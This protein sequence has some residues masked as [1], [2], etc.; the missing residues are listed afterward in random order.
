MLDEKAVVSEGPSEGRFSIS[1]S[2]SFRSTKEA[3]GLYYSGTYT[4]A[5]SP[6]EADVLVRS[7]FEQIEGS[8]E[9]GPWS[10]NL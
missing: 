4:A 2:H 9:V 3:A 5:H 10:E 8:Y 7:W 1:Y 6:E